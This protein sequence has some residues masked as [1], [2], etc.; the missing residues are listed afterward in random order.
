MR[1]PM[2]RH[3]P[4]TLLIDADD[5]LWENHSYFMRVFERWLEA[6]LARG[7]ASSSV[8]E[9][10]RIEEEER[11]QRTGYGSRNFIAS[12]IASIVRLENAVDDELARE[13]EELGEWIHEHPIELKDG[14]RATLEDLGLRHRLLLVTKGHPLEQTRKIARSGVG[15]HFLG[16]EVLREKDPAHYVD[17]IA[18]HALDASACWMI[19]NSP[20]S[21]IIAA[22]G[23]GLRTVH[24][25]HHTTWE[26]EHREG[27][28]SPDLLLT[29]FQD[30][31]LHF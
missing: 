4:T 5:T 19:G 25:P 16:T 11:T 28:C 21:D 31:A 14:V 26:L 7:H 29:R 1:N 15:Q 8:H 3:Q 9:A 24:I 6:M 17:V 18:R 27:P 13:L 22:Q 23:A 2:A 20:R 12:L 30:L 10:F